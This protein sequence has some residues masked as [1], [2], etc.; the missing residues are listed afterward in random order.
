LADSREKMVESAASLIAHRGVN[1]T[2]F[3]EVVSDSGAPR[4]SIYHHFPDG[5]RELTESAIRWTSDQMLAYL[6]RAPVG[7]ASEVLDYFIGIW[8]AVVLRSGGS[9]GCAVAGV[10]VDTVDDPLMLGEIRSTFRSWVG[11]LAE[12]LGD[13]G[14]PTDRA[15]SIATTALATMEGA[16][17]LCRAEGSGDALEL[18]AKE[19]ARLLPLEPDGTGRPGG[20]TSDE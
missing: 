1:A 12:Q 6:R 7:S 15:V 20:G 16:L 17:I 4:G 5:K 9:A 13:S 11:V 3:S 8:R 18:T 10:A 19:L 14:I 2:S